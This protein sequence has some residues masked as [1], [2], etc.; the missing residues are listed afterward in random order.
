MYYFFSFDASKMFGSSSSVET[1]G[2]GLV[3]KNYGLIHP[4]SAPILSGLPQSVPPSI[5]GA[6]SAPRLS[7]NPQSL[8]S[9]VAVGSGGSRQFNRFKV[10]LLI[11]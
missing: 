1:A 10:V 9:L 3:F 7:R 4:G 5:T 11:F 6:P 8:R 2:T